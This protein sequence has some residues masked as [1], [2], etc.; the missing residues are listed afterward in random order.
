MQFLWFYAPPIH[1]LGRIVHAVP[2][3]HRN[4][5]NAADYAQRAIESCGT[6]NQ[7]RSFA[8][9]CT[10]GFRLWFQGFLQFGVC[11]AWP[12]FAPKTTNRIQNPYTRYTLDSGRFVRLWPVE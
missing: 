6:V 2:M 3:L 4:I 1:K 8:R 5:E 10:S 12:V 7:K 9:L 11:L